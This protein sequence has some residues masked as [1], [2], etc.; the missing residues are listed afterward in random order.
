MLVFMAIFPWPIVLL[1]YT[2]ILVPFARRLSPF[3]KHLEMFGF[4]IK[5]LNYAMGS[6]WV[7]VRIFF[8]G[9]VFISSPLSISRQES[10]QVIFKTS[11]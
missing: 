3:S 4:V 1:P 8:N 9:H 6:A 2:A 11:I 7:P 10:S 5:E